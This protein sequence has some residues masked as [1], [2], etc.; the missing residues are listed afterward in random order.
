MVFPADS[1]RKGL[2]CPF[3]LLLP[4]HYTH[5]AVRRTR[6]VSGS[7]APFP[8]FRLVSSPVTS[9]PGQPATA[10]L[11]ESNCGGEARFRT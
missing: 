10:Y 1:S 6:N 4:L 11:R 8:I 9:T 3:N 2:R 7:D 5:R